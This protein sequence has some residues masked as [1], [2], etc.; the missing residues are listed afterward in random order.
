MAITDR[1][2][3]VY[4]LWFL[5][6]DPVLTLIG[7]WVNFFDHNL[8]MQAFFVDYP[9]DTHFAP[10][11]YQIGGMGTSYLI[12]Q[13][14]LLRYSHDVNIWKMFQ[15]CLLPADFTMFTA[16]YLG[17]KMEGNLAFSSWRWE[18]WFSVVVTGI[19]TVLRFGFVLGVGVRD[20]N[21]RA[22]KAYYYVF[23]KFCRSR[24]EFMSPQLYEIFTTRNDGLISISQCSMGKQIFSLS[25]PGGT[26]R[27][28][29][30]TT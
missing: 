12:L 29:L 9:L 14:T 1:I 20:T 7:M 24:A 11:L 15:G 13:C 30:I 21:G 4:T 23:G 5:W 8:A 27:P 6:V 26:H 25:L 19:C 2:H 3:P 16:I 22:K 17:L 28:T 18:D 10:Y